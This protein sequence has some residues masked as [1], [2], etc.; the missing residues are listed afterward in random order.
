[1]N[2]GG[3]YVDSPD[4]VKSQET[5]INPVNDDDKFFQHPATIALNYKK[6]VKH[7]ERT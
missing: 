4:W 6:I 3:S 2:H 7:P 5:T 1:M